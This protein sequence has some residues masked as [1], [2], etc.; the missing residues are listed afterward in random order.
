MAYAPMSLRFTSLVILTAVSF[1]AVVSHTSAQMT[2]DAAGMSCSEFI[3]ARRTGSPSH[4]QYEHGRLWVLGYLAGYY[5]ASG[6]L[7]LTNDVAAAES[8]HNLL[9]QMCQGFPESSLQS[10]SMLTLATETFKLPAE[11][12][13]GFR[14]ESYTCGQHIEIKDAGQTGIAEARE[15]WAF[16]FIQGYKNVEQPYAVIPSD[17]MPALTSIIV[18]NCRNDREVLFMDYAEGVAKA[19]RVETAP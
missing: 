10:V 11:P 7:E 4:A 14:P 17:S 15:L 18:N 6:E 9:L 19:V 8:V 12:S 5:T 3:S 1:V 13:T 2:F 16:A